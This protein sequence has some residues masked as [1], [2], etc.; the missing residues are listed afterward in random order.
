MEDVS[1]DCQLCHQHVKQFIILSAEPSA[2]VAA[3]R[4]SSPRHRPA[5]AR[6]A[7][8]QHGRLL[9][10]STSSH[11]TSLPRELFGAELGGGGGG[12]FLAQQ[13]AHHKARYRPWLL[14]LLITQLLSYLLRC[15]SC[16]QHPVACDPI[17]GHRAGIFG[18]GGT[19]AAVVVVCVEDPQAPWTSYNPCAI[20]TSPTSWIRWWR[21]AT[22]STLA[23]RAASTAAR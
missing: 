14:L 23:G 19:A 18:A 6:G 22:R 2:R 8:H 20:S 4:R 9:A 3:L 16:A 12:A 7:R 1:A 15:C 13:L 17:T 21:R 10:G 11:P 5:A